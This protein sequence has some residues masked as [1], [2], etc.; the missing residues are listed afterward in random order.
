MATK[1]M[2]RPQEP[3]GAT[4]RRKGRAAGDR[5]GGSGDGAVGTPRK[6]ASSAPRG[7]ATRPDDLGD[8][9]LDELLTALRPFSFIKYLY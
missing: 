1:P 8:A 5:P 2:A 3:G 7:S 4:Q 9:R 6:P